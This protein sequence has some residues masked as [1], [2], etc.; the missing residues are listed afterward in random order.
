MKAMK[1]VF[2]NLEECFNKLAI[3]MHALLA[4]VALIAVR[5]TL[6][7][8]ENSYAASQHPVPFYVAQT[9]FSGETL[10]GYYAT[11][12]ASGTL[13][14]Y[15]RTQ[16]IDFLYIASVFLA[17]IIVSFLLARFN[18]NNPRLL[19]LSLVAAIAIPTGAIFDALENLTS[20]IMLSQPTSFPNWIALIYSSFAVLKGA[21]VGLGVIL[22][23]ICLSGLL[24]E[25][26]LQR[27]RPNKAMS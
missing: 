7:L 12:I 27:F 3:T 15:W 1:R 4:L 26:T 16:F 11:M 21:T 13:A 23:L 18:N 25:L 6:T 20:F 5:V 9:A 24:I 10:K 22:W 8:F 14:V 2:N 17:G 19:K